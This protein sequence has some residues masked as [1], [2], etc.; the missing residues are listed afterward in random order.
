M[1]FTEHKHR[2]TKSL[3]GVFLNERFYDFV[4]YPYIPIYLK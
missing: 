4:H 1:K 3:L 2:Y